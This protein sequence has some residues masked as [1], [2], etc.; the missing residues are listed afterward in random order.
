VS[1]DDVAAIPAE[2]NEETVKAIVRAT[3][4]PVVFINPTANPPVIGRAPI[5]VTVPGIVILVQTETGLGLL[6]LN[7]VEPELPLKTE[8]PESI[9]KLVERGTVLPTRLKK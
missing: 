7:P 8:V 2:M 1:I 6:V 3:Q 4:R 9:L 5:R